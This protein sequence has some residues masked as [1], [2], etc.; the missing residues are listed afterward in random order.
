M[1]P[2]EMQWNALLQR[3]ATVTVIVKGQKITGD[4]YNVTDEQVILIVPNKQD[5]FEVIARA[6]IDEINW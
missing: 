5:L 6:D 2:T 3:H 1:I 4:L